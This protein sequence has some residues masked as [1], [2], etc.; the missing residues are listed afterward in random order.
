M[1]VYI[2]INWTSY[3]LCTC[4][5]FHCVVSRY[6]KQMLHITQCTYYAVYSRTK[7]PELMT[8]SVLSVC[9]GFWGLLCV[10]IF[11]RRC[12]ILEV[13]SELCYCASNNLPS[14]VCIYTHHTC[15]YIQ[16]SPYFLLFHHNNSTWLLM[17]C[18]QYLNQKPPSSMH[19]VV[20]CAYKCT[21]VVT[22]CTPSFLF[23]LLQHTHTTLL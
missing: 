6:S 19:C 9:S 21:Y 1:H 4:G 16:W 2:V 20:N 13:Y 23:V 7:L 10:G 17:M 8:H 18:T 5:Y 11:S 3:V 14:T 15:T 22:T 12:L